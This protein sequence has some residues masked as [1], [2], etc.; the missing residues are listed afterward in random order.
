[1]VKIAFFVPN[2]MNTEKSVTS[3]SKFNEQDIN[4]RSLIA[5]L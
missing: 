2:E 3:L 5:F 1:M 4:T